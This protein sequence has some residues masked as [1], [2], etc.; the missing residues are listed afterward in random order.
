[1]AFTFSR[2]KL[3]QKYAF[4]KGI[5]I[6]VLVLFF[7][8]VLF[9]FWKY[10]ANLQFSRILHFWKE[11]V[12]ILGLA[13]AFLMAKSFILYAGG[14][15]FGKRQRYAHY[16]KVYCASLFIELTTFSGKFGADGFKILFWNDLSL[17]RRF[18]LI[19][20]VRGIEMV[21]FLIFF[22]YLYFSPS[23]SLLLVLLA[24]AVLSVVEKW[25]RGNNSF[26]P[27][28]MSMVLLSLLSYGI[29]LLQLSIVFSALGVIISSE[30]LTS[31]LVS[32]GLGAISQLPLGLGVKDFSLAYLLRN[33]LPTETIFFALIWVRLFSDFCVLLLGGLFSVLYF[34]RKGKNEDLNESVS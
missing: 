31:F 25:R 30:T 7:G 34:R 15:M 22:C 26:T 32:H 12:T 23:L 14:W 24:L 18:Q 9:F 8:Y 3:L 27:V 1:M 16:V 5:Q 29:L 4:W 6:L 33:S 13:V 2:S 28:L 11:S 20:L 19:L 17:K 10:G 21:S